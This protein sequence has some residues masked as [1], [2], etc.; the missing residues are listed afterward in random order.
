MKL[1]RTGLK[2]GLIAAAL[3]VGRESKSAAP[4]VPAAAIT[5]P[6]FAQ[7]Y[8]PEIRLRKVHLVRPDLIFYPLDY[9]IF[10]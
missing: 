8:Y 5:T 6:A 3:L 1:L 4:A 2:L 7:T 10:C 9:E